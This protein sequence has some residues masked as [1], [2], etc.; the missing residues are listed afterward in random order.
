MTLPAELDQLPTRTHL[1]LRARAMRYISAGAIAMLVAGL[2][3]SLAGF[4]AGALIWRLHG[5][6]LW[7]GLSAVSGVLAGLWTSRKGRKLLTADPLLITGHVVRKAVST[8][9]RRKRLALVMQVK[10]A[11]VLHLEKGSVLQPEL[12]GER[13]VFAREVVYRSLEPDAERCVHLVCLPTGEAL[14][15]AEPPEGEAPGEVPAA[16]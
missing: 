4:F 1:A 13:T 12:V 16:H 11:A 7:A 2:L 10:Q 14:F 8:A 3:F 5:D 15:L 6:L 9:G